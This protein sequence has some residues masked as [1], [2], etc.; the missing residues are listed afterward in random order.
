MIFDITVRKKYIGQYGKHIICLLHIHINETD[1]ALLSTTFN[2]QWAVLP[3]LLQLLS[4]TLLSIGGI[5]FFVSQTPYSMR[6]LIIGAGY[7]SVFVFT[8]IGYGL[9]GLFSQQFWGIG[10]TSCEFWYFL[11]V[12]LVLIIFSGL[13]LAV[14]RWYKNRKREDVLP[15]EH[16]FREVLFTIKLMYY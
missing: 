7:G 10:I 16:I 8:L 6:G 4:L 2:S 12:L 14:G 5:E 3:L 15:N 13:L 1:Q 11:S 9:Y